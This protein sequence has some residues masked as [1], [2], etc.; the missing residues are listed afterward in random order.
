LL[1]TGLSFAA[2]IDH[3]VSEDNSGIWKRSNQ[4]ALVCTL[5]GGRIAGALWEGG[6]TRLGKTFWQAIDSSALGGCLVGGDEAYLHATEIGPI[7][8]SRS[9]SACCRMDS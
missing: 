4:Q 8:R 6:Q 1:Y 9:S 3:T 5:I 2:G 7:Q